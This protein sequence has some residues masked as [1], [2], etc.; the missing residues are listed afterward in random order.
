MSPR[1]SD[2]DKEA[3]DDDMFEAEAEKDKEKPTVD[4]LT[5]EDLV[6]DALEAVAKEEEP[7]SPA[8]DV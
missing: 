7:A 3:A 4:E 2:E 5:A 8:D 6:E 1:G